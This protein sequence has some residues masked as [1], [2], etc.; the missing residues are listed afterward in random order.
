M[1]A[2]QLDGGI[3]P[4]EQEPAAVIIGAERHRGARP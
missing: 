1:T 4:A 3:L 2:L